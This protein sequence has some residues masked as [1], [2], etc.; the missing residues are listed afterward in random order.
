[1][2]LAEGLRDIDPDLQASDHFGLVPDLQP[3]AHG[4]RRG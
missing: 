1:M 2:V 4:A 3:T